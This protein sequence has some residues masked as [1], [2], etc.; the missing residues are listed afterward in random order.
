[1]YNA[2]CPSFITSSLPNC[3]IC[4]SVY[5]FSGSKTLTSISISA[6]SST[7]K[8]NSLSSFNSVDKNAI[9]FSCLIIKSSDIADSKYSFPKYSAEK[10]CSLTLISSGIVQTN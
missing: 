6:S 10:I 9:V 8:H 5:S 4:S 2:T 7:A 1:M 3:L